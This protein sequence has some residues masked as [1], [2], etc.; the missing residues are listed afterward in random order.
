[1]LSTGVH[2]P[3]DFTNS[4]E[5]TMNEQNL[6]TLR[7]STRCSACKLPEEVL[8]A[9]HQDRFESGMG[10]ERLALKYSQHR[11]LSEAGVRRHFTRHAA[12]PSDSS[13]SGTEA[14]ANGL[15]A[16]AASRDDTTPSD[17]LDGHALLEAGTRTLGEMV[18]ALAREYREAASQQ[19]AQGAERAFTKFMKA[20]SELAKCVRQ[21]EVGRRVRNEFRQTV[22]E[23]VG[24]CTLAAMHSILPVMRENAKRIRDEVVEYSQGTLSREEF[25]NRLMRYEVEWPREIPT[26]MKAAQT[27]ALKGE[28]VKVQA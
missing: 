18:E 5:T 28:E 25:W 24:R 17:D 7:R 1:M 12:G 11:P 4:G 22:P 2:A 3:V 13:I 6:V 20:Q 26:R 27:E 10:F 21:V 19:R 9:F 23:I 14:P 8:G 16:G 15:D